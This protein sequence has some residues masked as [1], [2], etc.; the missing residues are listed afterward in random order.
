[1]TWDTT[2]VAIWRRPLHLWT[3][4]HDL[5]QVLA[6]THLHARPQQPD[7]FLAHVVPDSTPPTMPKLSL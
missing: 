6:A 7:C 3:C 5:N 1:M 4:M 2:H